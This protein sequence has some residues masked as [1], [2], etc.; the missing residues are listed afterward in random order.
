MKLVNTV[1]YSHIYKTTWF[2]HTF[3]QILIFTTR[4]SWKV[5]CAHFHCE[6]TGSENNESKINSKIGTRLSLFCLYLMSTTDVFSPVI[7]RNKKENAIRLTTLYRVLISLPLK[8]GSYST[9]I[10]WKTQTKPH[11]GSPRLSSRRPW[12]KASRGRPS[13]QG[14]PETHGRHNKARDGKSHQRERRRATMCPK[15]LGGPL[16]LGSRAESAAWSH[17]CAARVRLEKRRAESPSGTLFACFSFVSVI[18][19]S[20][21]KDFSFR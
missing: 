17:A 15:A 16:S 19:V 14:H 21:F 2:I 7:L 4:W 5:A 3:I 11:P 12:A 10:P 8:G 18:L 6:Q 13:R 20:S 9:F 1:K